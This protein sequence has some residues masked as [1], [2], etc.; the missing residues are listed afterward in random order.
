MVRWMTHE[1]DPFV[2]ENARC[3]PDPWPG[4]ASSNN[5]LKGSRLSLPRP[6]QDVLPLGQLEITIS[7]WHLRSMMLPFRLHQTM[8]N[9]KCM[10]CMTRSMISVVYT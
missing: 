1:G 2:G 8:V 3:S 9:A 6:R 10:S 7:V 4:P 5:T